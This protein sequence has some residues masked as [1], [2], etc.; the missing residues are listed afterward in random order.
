MTSWYL[1]RRNHCYYTSQG[2]FRS[3]GKLQHTQNVTCVKDRAAKF[4]MRYKADTWF[5]ERCAITE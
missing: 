3:W 4:D 5:Y 2:F 1:R